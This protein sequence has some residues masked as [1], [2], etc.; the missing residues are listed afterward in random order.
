MP[1][2]KSFFLALV[3]G[4]VLFVRSD[5]A[6]AITKFDQILGI[7][8]SQAIGQNILG[9]PPLPR[10]E[11][12]QRSH[13]TPMVSYVE[14]NVD[15]PTSTFAP[16]DP[17]DPNS[18]LV[19]I[20]TYSGRLQGWTAGAGLT[21]SSKQNWSVYAFGNMSRVEG[22]IKRT[23]VSYPLGLKD[24]KN[25]GYN[26]S[27]GLS[28][29]LW[30][31]KT[32]PI[33]LGV[34]GGPFISRFDSK[35]NLDNGTNASY[36]STSFIYGPMLGLQALL[37]IKRLEFNPFFLQY[38]DLSDPCQTYSTTVV[39]E[40]V[41]TAS[42]A[43]C[44]KENREIRMEGSFYSYGLNVSI[45]GLAFGAYSKVQENEDLETVEVHNYSLSYTFSY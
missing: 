21:Q 30:S 22:E 35:F 17:S 18:Q 10:L 14:V 38:W 36:R 1:F 44:S 25:S 4:L 43:G 13:F 16:S 28:C 42:A 23:D 40:T 39:G 29:R 7:R 19:G 5:R 34:L 12:K 15:N 37:R 33:V 45:F 6:E 31:E 27:V 11:E 26:L 32:F 2:L 24:M 41:D 3:L 9:N 20:P 8:I